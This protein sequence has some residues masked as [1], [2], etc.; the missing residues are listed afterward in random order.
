MSSQETETE[1]TGFARMQDRV[2]FEAAAIIFQDKIPESDRKE[3]NLRQWIV[4]WKNVLSKAKIKKIA[5]DRILKIKTSVEDWKTVLREESFTIDLKR[6][7]IS[8]IIE[9]T[10]EIDDIDSCIRAQSISQL[11]ES[12]INKALAKLSAMEG[13]FEEWGK[14]FRK[15]WTLTVDAQIKKI[16]FAKM[17]KMESTFIQWDYFY[18]NTVLDDFNDKESLNIMM[19]KART[20]DQWDIMISRL[21]NHP[22]LKKRAV[23]EVIKLTQKCSELITVYFFL[24]PGSQLRDQVVEK[25]KESKGEFQD[26]VRINQ[27]VYKKDKLKKMSLQKMKES[28]GCCADWN[29]IFHRTDSEEEKKTAILKMIEVAK[30]I[31]EAELAYYKAFTDALKKKAIAKMKE[32]ADAGKIGQFVE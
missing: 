32:L 12:F 10:T 19:E 3:F 23:K 6:L 25:I 18:R 1:M 13:P 9:L 15:A 22:D 7:S 24:D 27:S 8:R 2:G 17:K 30:D 21:S 31:E 11:T 16:A 20:F 4:I 29:T 28:A 14:I 26:W 5:W